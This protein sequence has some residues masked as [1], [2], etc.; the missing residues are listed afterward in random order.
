MSSSSSSS[1]CILPLKLMSYLLSFSSSSSSPKSEYGVCNSDDSSRLLKDYATREFNAFLWISL[2]A[3]TALL[4]EKVFKLIRL[5]AQ[6]RK[7]AGPP[8]NT[9]FGHRNFGSRE[10]F[11]DLLSELHNKYGSVFKLWLGPTQ[12]MV[13]I[14]DPELI[15]EMLS[16]AKDKL[17][18]TGKAFRL[19]F[20]RSSLFFC[21]YEEAQKRRESLAFQFNKKL[22]GRTD[23]IP[24]HVMDFIKV[25]LDETVGKGSVDSKLVSQHMAFTLLGTTLF[26]DAFLGWSNAN[27]YEEL[28]MMIAKDASFWASFR[29]TPFWRHRFWRYQSLCAKLRYLT[30]DIIQLCRKNSKLF[31]QVDENSNDETG[32]GGLKPAASMPPF[33]IVLPDKCFSR[34]VDGDPNPKEEP[35][36]NI[37]GMMF[38]GCI[39]TAGLIGNIL[40]RLVTDLNIQDKI[41]SEISKV[42]EGSAKDVQSVDKMV[43]LLATIYES[44][45][46]LPPGQLLQRCSVKED[47]RLKNGVI[48][49]A[50]AV[51]VV[52]VHLLQMDDA[53]WG[54][55][56]S[57]F[58]PYRFLSKVGRVSDS[59]QDS[60]ITDV[61]EDVIDNQTSFILN[62]PNKNAAFLSFG[63][64][65]RSC[66]GQEYIIRGVASLLASLLECY[67][68][69]RQPASENDPKSTNSEILFVRRNN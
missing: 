10:N 25:K 63:S 32:K 51:L 15:K 45:R 6:G 64:G 47:L 36:G 54:N 19:A 17:P 1:S 35:C 40:E 13:S 29:V 50:G 30:Q 58:N 8:C 5:W 39:A 42:R 4:L 18:F 12:L 37:T 44:A 43:L 66:V 61:A 26:G 69:K 60:S 53:S 67:E 11:L 23:V 65:L 56:A 9:F 49:P 41:Y 57:K 38:H 34:E 52:P 27:F 21:S 31:H 3:I 46:L 28:L 68:V 2:V 24:E 16:K 48:I 62:Y 33:G 14:K 7:I 22:H 20:G 59:D 55:D